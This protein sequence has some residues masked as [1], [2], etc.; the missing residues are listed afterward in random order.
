M[1]RCI[2]GFIEGDGERKAGKEGDVLC[3]PKLGKIYIED[4][5][6]N[7]IERKKKRAT[8][9][10]G[11]YLELLEPLLS[12]RGRGDLEYV[13]TNCLGKRSALAN[14]H[15]ITWPY[16]PKRVNRIILTALQTGFTESHSDIFIYNDNY[17]QS[18]ATDIK[19]QPIMW[20]TGSKLT[21]IL[22]G[23]YTAMPM[24]TQQEK[25]QGATLNPIKFLPEAGRDVDRH[26]LMPLLKSETITFLEI[27]TAILSILILK[28]LIFLSGF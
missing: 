11:F 21:I 4:F 19:A 25:C 26:V 1:N 24:E 3:I 18:V 28:K 7:R 9:S 27:Y 5:T 17:N 16:I 6:N 8:F 22:P 20:E 12:T 13:V 23:L 15:N 2:Y 14:C 10:T